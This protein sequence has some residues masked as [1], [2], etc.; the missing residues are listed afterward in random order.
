MRD[1]PRMREILSGNSSFADKWDNF[2]ESEAKIFL[3]TVFHY[4]ISNF[5]PVWKKRPLAIG[6]GKHENFFD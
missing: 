1:V 2:A 3:S 5:Q 4:L 6:G